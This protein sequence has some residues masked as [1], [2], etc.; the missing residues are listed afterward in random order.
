MLNRA[1]KLLKAHRTLAQIARKERVS[2][3]YSNTSAVL[4]GPMVA[5]RLK[6]PHIW[7]IHEII[8][9]SKTFNK[10]ILLM[11][12]MS[13]GRVIAVSNA[14]MNHW[15]NQ[16]EQASIDVI[17]NGMDYSPFLDSKANP[18]QQ[19]GLPANMLI[20]GMVGR[21]NLV[22]GQPFF[23][24]IAEKLLSAGIMAKFIMAGDPYPGTEHLEEQLNERISSSELLRNNVIN[25][26]YRSDVHNVIHAMDVYVLP[27]V[28]PDSLPTTILEAM[29]AGKPV[30][31]TK[32]GGASEMVIDAK[33]GYLIEVGDSVD[34]A[35]RIATLLES[36]HLRKEFGVSGRERVLT[37]FSIE[38]YRTEFANVFKELIQ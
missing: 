30:V 35:Q 1:Q 34:A 31:A 26:G 20:V 3:I 21:I 14:V 29:A 12:K 23:L 15:R 27:S 2:L 17:Y 19:L 37:Q 6:I 25:L 5:R 10:L 33:T 16:D 7:H 32:S 28:M 36:D 8:P 38:K 22:K 11:M 4:I 18:R 9:G 24:D 13:R